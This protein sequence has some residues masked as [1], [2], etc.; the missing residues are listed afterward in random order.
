MLDFVLELPRLATLN[1]ADNSFKTESSANVPI[2][3][4]PCVRGYDRIEKLLEYDL[5]YCKA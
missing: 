5:L 4:D 2:V 3:I 1:A